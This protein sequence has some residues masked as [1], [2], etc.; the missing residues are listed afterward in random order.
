MMTGEP[1]RRRRWLGTGQF[2]HLAAKDL[3]Q[4]KPEREYHSG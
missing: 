4:H 1:R 3:H 2:S